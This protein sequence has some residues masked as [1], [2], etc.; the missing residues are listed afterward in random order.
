MSSRA[1]APQAAHDRQQKDNNIS[2]GQD[3]QQTFLHVFAAR[4]REQQASVRFFRAF[5]V[6]GAVFVN[7]TRFAKVSEED[8]HALDQVLLP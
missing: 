6:R 7:E 3:S 1:I 5:T 4:I 2:E 8:I